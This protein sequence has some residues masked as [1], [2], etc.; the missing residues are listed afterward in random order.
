MF[1]TVRWYRQAAEV[2]DGRRRVL[3]G[4]DPPLPNELVCKIERAR[5]T[6]LFVAGGTVI[7]KPLRAGCCPL[8]T[9]WRLPCRSTMQRR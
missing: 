9:P 1:D 4:A 8:R 5:V 7:R 6:R 3:S 2:S